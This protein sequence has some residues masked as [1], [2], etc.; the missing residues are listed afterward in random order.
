[1]KLKRTAAGVLIFFLLFCLLPLSGTAEL[2]LLSAGNTYPLYSDKTITWYSQWGLIPN[3]A[4]VD[5]TQS[6]FHTGLS[7]KLGVD[8]KW[9]F[10]TTGT[11]GTTYTNI[12]LMDPATMPNIMDINGNLIMNNASMY[13]DDGVIWDLTDDLPKY[14]PAYYAFLKAHPEWDRAVKTDDDK[15]YF[16]GFF[17]ED[18]GWNDSCIGP[19]IRKDWLEE[20]GLEAPKTISE[21]E[22]VLRV[23]KDK[24]NARFAFNTRINAEGG[25]FCGAFGAYTTNSDT[26][27]VRDG[28]V[29]YAMTQPEWRTYVSWLHKLWKEGLIDQDSLT[30]DDTTIKAKIHSDKCGVS[31]TAMSQVN[32]WNRERNANGQD[33]VWI[34]FTPPTAD[35]G[36]ISC[37]VGGNGLVAFTVVITKSASL[38]EKRLAMQMLD[39]AYTQ[40]GFLYWNYGEKG[41]SWEYGEDG[42]PHF[43]DLVMNDPDMDPMTKYNGATWG[44]SCVQAT[45]LLYAKNSKEATDANDAWYYVFDDPVKNK[46]VTSDWKFPIGATFTVEEADEL[47]IIG[48]G[49]ATYA[50]ENFAK[51][52]TGSLDIDDDKVWE[53]YLAGF[54]QLSLPRVLEIKQASYDRFIKRD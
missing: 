50:S 16:F 25:G 23:F 11:N 48:G 43:T 17:R 33:S 39:Y 42:K 13:L 1:M 35:D 40:E 12:L 49:I 6:P 38:E 14:A 2:E 24:Y 15:Y 10:P 3:Q 8:I 51:F 26:Y 34:G 22:N 9:M 32:N 30:L 52:L 45:N 53:R 4:F 46:A 20:C 27:F 47:D 44:S 5:Y 19:T 29:G 54:D 37:V 7:K 41:V 18:G 28:K 31:F 21:L 36:S